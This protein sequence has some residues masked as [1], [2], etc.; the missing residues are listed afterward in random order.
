MALSVYTCLD[1]LY[2]SRSAVTNPK[3][4]LSRFAQQ[5]AFKNEDIYSETKSQIPKI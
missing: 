4:A 2:Y 1:V 5:I 3:A